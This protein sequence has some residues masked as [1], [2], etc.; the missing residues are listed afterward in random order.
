[1]AMVTRDL[2][3]HEPGDGDARITLLL[4]ERHD[5]MMRLAT[6]NAGRRVLV[7]CY[8]LGSTARP[9]VVLQAEAAVERA[10]IDVTLLYTRASGPLKTGMR[11]SSPRRR[12]TMASG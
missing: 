6:G 4:G 12:P 9:G 2:R 1:M 8:R 7:G 11:G 10:D 5:E 3:R